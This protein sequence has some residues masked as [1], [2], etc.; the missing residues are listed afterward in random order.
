MNNKSDEEKELYRKKLS[1]A[2]LGKNKGKQP[3][4]KGLTKETDERVAINAKHTSSAVLIKNSK[5]K[6][7][8]PEYFI[9]WRKTVSNK[10]KQNGT[11][12]TSKPE[13]NYYMELINKYGENNVIRQ[14]SDER[15]PFNCDFYIPSEDLFIEINKHWTHGGKP[16]DKLD[17]K[18]VSKLKNWEEKAEISQFYKNA[19]YVWTDLDVR[20]QKCAKE[21]NLNYK[22]IY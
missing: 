15:Y 16:F 5:L 3:W 18:D 2:T 9:N 14:Y 12:G 21:N 4:N 1:N 17:L 22:V 8:N 13:E 19:I 6:Q 20:K 11:Y 10:M 7:S